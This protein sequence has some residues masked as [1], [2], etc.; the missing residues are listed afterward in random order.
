M[1]TPN[2]DYLIAKLEKAARNAANAQNEAQRK[3]AQRF[4]I[5]RAQELRAERDRLFDGETQDGWLV[6]AWD[7]LRQNEDHPEYGARIDALTA[8]T[9][10]YEQICDA[11][12]AAI[13]VWLP[14][15]DE[16]TA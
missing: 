4:L 1:T 8:A 12:N 13:S 3:A 5:Q 7:W 14:L 9:R 11:L 15:K 16:V 6:R 2:P 10:T